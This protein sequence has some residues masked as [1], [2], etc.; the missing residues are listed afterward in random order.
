VNP[1]PRWAVWTTFALSI[2]G[3]GVSIYLTITHFQPQLL[4][5]SGSG[6]VNCAAVTTS[7]QSYFL[8]IPV[9][10]LGLAQYT[11]MTA[12]NSPFGWKV[13]YRWVHI[14]RLALAGVG[15]AFILWLI[16]A[17][18]LIIGHICLW[19]T[20]VHVVTLALVIILTR[21]SPRQLGWVD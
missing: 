5:C 2:F 6:V 9:A 21:V 13:P 8:G 12:L 10:I 17:E 16:S 20:S 14:G 18:I 1:V 7:A 15:T 3:L 4:V 19:C 11:A